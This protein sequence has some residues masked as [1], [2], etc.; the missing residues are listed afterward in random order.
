M[1]KKLKENWINR[2]IEGENKKAEVVV[3][4]SVQE[5]VEELCLWGKSDRATTDVSSISLENGQEII[6]AVLSK[7]DVTLLIVVREVEEGAKVSLSGS[8]KGTSIRS[9]EKYLDR[10]IDAL[11]HY[12]VKIEKNW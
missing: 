1:K 5:V 2:F 6:T 12:V 4:L 8:V 7:N 11:V 10:A 3:T 9:A